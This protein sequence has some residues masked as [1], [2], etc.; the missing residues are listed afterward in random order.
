MCKGRIKAHFLIQRDP[1]RLMK[2]F[3]L[4]SVHLLEEPT[5][6]FVAAAIRM[7]VPS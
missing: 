3:G 2:D 4:I 1:G 7:E 5:V 6:A